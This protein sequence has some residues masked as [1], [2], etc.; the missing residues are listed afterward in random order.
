MNILLVD[1][2]IDCI[3][4]LDMALQPLNF[5]ITKTTDPKTALYLIE[6]K[7]FDLVISDYKMPG[8]NGVELLKR[9][10]EINNKICVI[11]MT[12]YSNF[13]QNMDEVSLLTY[14]ILRKPINI[15]ELIKIIREIESKIQNDKT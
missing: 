4:S 13:E 11:I 8:M 14:A 9:I 1:D 6:R 2:E 10:K 12:A 5:Q 7:N 3:N 15:I